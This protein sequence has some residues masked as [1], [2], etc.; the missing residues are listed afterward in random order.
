MSKNKLS[1]EGVQNLMGNEML[2]LFEYECSRL[3]K[4]VY[5]ADDR[6]IINVAYEYYIDLSR[7]DTVEKILGWCLHLNEKN[8]MDSRLLERF[9][10][11]ACE[12]NNIPFRRGPG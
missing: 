7:C 8:W 1:E 10:Y 9:V 6:I 3:Q 12:A 4:Q 5:L 2:S 11:L